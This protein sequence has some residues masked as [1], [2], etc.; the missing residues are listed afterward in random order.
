M[1]D[2]IEVK[3][4]EIRKARRMLRELYSLSE[5]ASLTGAFKKDGAQDAVQAYNQILTYVSAQGIDLQGMF[6]PLPEDASFS[7]L[8]VASR[9]L[10]SLLEEEEE[11]ADKKGVKII[12]GK[13]GE[14]SGHISIEELGKLKDIG[15]VIREHL[16]DFLKTPTAPPTPPTPP[17]PPAPPTPPFPPRDRDDE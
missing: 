8:G 7:R 9:L 11:E 12:V 4:K 2:E 6:S 1:S 15:T 16:P 17:A 5:H 10:R 14:A 3:A 13:H